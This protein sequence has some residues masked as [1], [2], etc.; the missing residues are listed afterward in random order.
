MININ[1][2]I[3]F[4]SYV[5]CNG[6]LGY[7]ERKDSFSTRLV[8]KSINVFISYFEKYLH[9][10]II[11][12]SLF[13]LGSDINVIPHKYRYLL[14]LGYIKRYSEKNFSADGIPIMYKLGRSPQL[15]YNLIEA[16]SSIVMNNNGGIGGHCFFLLKDLKI[17]VYP[18]DD[19]G[20]GFISMDDKIKDK[21]SSYCTVKD[22]LSR[23]NPKIFQYQIINI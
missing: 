10:T 19:T 8:N 3:N 13:Y 12:S 15:N 23:L 14:N 9:N 11:Y 17:L 20:F 1:N 2:Y 6:W 4:K 18:H 21:L 5:D 22:F 7:Y 16:L